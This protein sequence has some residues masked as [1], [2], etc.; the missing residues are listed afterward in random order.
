[1]NAISRT[2]A[3][4]G[5]ALF[6]NAAQAVEYGSVQADKSTVTFTSRQMGV[7]VQGGFPKFTTK[8]AFDPAKPEA[9]K[10]E[11]SIDLATIDAGSKDANDEVVGKQWFNVKMFP[12]AT[13][14]SATV[15]SVGAG[16]FEVTGPLT[17]KGKS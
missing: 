11:L 17:I 8:L 14:T 2:F 5:V 10:V 3:L 16:G 15:K 9:A 13:F 6:A 4:A 1:M 7:P 12:V